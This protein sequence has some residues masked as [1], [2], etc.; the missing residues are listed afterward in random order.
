MA[1]RAMTHYQLRTRSD[2][3]AKKARCAC[4]WEGVWRSTIPTGHRRRDAQ[5]RGVLI[6]RD[7]ERHQALE[8]PDAPSAVYGYRRPGEEATMESETE[9]LT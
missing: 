2:R 6:R 9:W 3:T 8:L 4:G 5:L 1:E 7:F